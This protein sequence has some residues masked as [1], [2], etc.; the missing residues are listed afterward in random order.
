[1]TR[2]A[3]ASP[4]RAK[5]WRDLRRL[6]GPFIAVAVT[7]FLG[8]AL[9]GTSYGAYRNLVASYDRLFEVTGFADLTVAGG[10]VEGFAAS[11][12]GVPGV[13]AVTTRT[14]VDT[15]GEV[16]GRRLAVRV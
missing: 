4:W 2:G 7:S 9:F 16:N 11:A 15:F 6:R 8:V 10:D 12:A 1:M 13:D 14:V 3:G 5:L